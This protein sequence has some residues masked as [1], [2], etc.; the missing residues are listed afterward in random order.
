M[1]AIAGRSTTARTHCE[2]RRPLC[3]NMLLRREVTR[4]A[5]RQTLDRVMTKQVLTPS[6][7]LPQLTAAVL[8][9]RHVDLNFYVPGCKADRGGCT[10]R[11]HPRCC[12][13][14]R[15][16]QTRQG[17]GCGLGRHGPDVGL[18]SQLDGR[19]KF[20]QG[21]LKNSVQESGRER[22]S[23]IPLGAAAL[24]IAGMLARE[25]ACMARL[26]LR[27]L[28]PDTGDHPH[29]NMS[30]DAPTVDTCC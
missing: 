3:A 9:N 10:R 20:Y 6:S 26:P 15:C 24:S 12:R 29:S 8:Q 17:P 13:S 11:T 25:A 22:P 4:A 7:L 16:T 21:E 18:A 23:S 14:S 2:T 27:M 1:L 19:Y 30:S 5:G 28:N